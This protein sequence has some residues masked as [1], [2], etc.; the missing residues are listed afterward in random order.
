MQF[1]ERLFK[2]PDN[3][4]GVRRST[5]RTAADEDL[6]S[7]TRGLRGRGGAG[8]PT[9]RKWLFTR[10]AKGDKK[11]VCCNA[12]EGDPGAFMDRSVLEGDPHC[13]A[14]K[15]SFTICPPFTRC[16]SATVLA[17]SGVICECFQ[18]GTDKRKT[19]CARTGGKTFA[20]HG[21]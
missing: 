7:I 8:F 1:F 4:Q 5:A 12:D 14:Y 17:C 16:F 9:G 2:L 20:P 13:S 21:L 15:S 3:L 18:S 10:E 19:T 6:L 11:Y